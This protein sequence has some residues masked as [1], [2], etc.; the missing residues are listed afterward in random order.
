MTS[1]AQ[2]Q[3][4]QTV[5]IVLENNWEYNDEYHTEGEG[6]TPTAARRTRQEAA[7]LADEK[8]R[9]AFRQVFS[10][11]YETLNAYTDAGVEGDLLRKAQQLW[12][13]FNDGSEASAQWLA[14]LKV[15]DFDFDDEHALEFL[16]IKARARENP[17]AAATEMRAF[18]ASQDVEGP[19]YLL[20]LTEEEAGEY[21]NEFTLPNDA[22][23]AQVDAVMAVFDHIFFYYVA[24][25]PLA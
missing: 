18:L 25:L 20:P 16:A 9:E 10:G 14:S 24:E 4:P 23:D 2:T 21:L 11:G 15:G 3:Q 6:G 19:D 17:E 5:F 7:A 12:R 22:T 13:A 1:N 8:N